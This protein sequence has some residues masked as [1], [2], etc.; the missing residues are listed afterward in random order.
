MY[1]EEMPIE[2]CPAIRAN[3]HTSQPDSPSRVRNVCRSEYSTNGRTGFRLCF[4][5]T[6]SPK[7]ARN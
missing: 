3:V 6:C 1:R 5:V 4:G 2:L 7:S